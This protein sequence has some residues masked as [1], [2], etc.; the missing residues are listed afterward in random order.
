MKRS[1]KSS[2]I[3]TAKR[4]RRRCPRVRGQELRDLKNARLLEAAKPVPGEKTPERQGPPLW[5]FLNTLAAQWTPELHNYFFATCDTL[6]LILECQKCRFEW[7]RR[8]LQFPPHDL[9]SRF[10][11]CRWVNKVHNE[12]NV[13][14]GKPSFPYARMVTEFGAPPE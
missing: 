4:I 1:G 10:A 13:H 6:E 9:N 7:R 5:L 11:V 3:T 8:L 12:I 14:L 2:G